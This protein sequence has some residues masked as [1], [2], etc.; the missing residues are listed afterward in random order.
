MTDAITVALIAMPAPTLLAAASLWRQHIAD[1]DRRIAEKKS[2]A[3][4]A[5]IKAQV[6]EV[7]VQSDGKYSELLN[8]LTAEIRINGF[9]AG[10]EAGKQEEKD[11]LE[12]R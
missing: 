4:A 2:E 11:R 12:E 6:V 5:A 1:R 9:H 10:K 7:K 3:A 8:A